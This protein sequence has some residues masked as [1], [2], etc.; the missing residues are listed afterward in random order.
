MENKKVQIKCEDGNYEL[1]AEIVGVRGGY[2]EL[3]A[4]NGIIWLIP[5]SN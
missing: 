4:S 1:E 3:Q 5:I 2:A